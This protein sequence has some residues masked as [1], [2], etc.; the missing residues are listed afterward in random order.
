MAQL[1][2]DL[3]GIDDAPLTVS[4]SNNP[5]SILRQPSGIG[6]FLSGKSMQLAAVGERMVPDDADGARERGALGV[7]TRTAIALV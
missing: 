5:R 7:L 2:G 4:G 3:P 6:F 1:R